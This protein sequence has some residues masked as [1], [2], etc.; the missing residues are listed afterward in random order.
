MFSL[1]KKSRKVRT[2]AFRILTRSAGS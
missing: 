1:L 2:L